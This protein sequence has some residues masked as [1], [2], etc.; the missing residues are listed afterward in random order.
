MKRAALILVV[1]LGAVLILSRTL[2]LQTKLTPSPSGSPMIPLSIAAMREKAY[3]GSAFTVVTTL[4]DT[5]EYHQ[6]VVSYVSDGLKIQGLLTE[7]KGDK[8]AGGWPAILFDHGYVDPRVYTPTSRYVEFV[9]DLTRAGYVVFK[10]DY[11]GNGKSE[12]VPDS[13]YFSP[14]YTIDN[15]NALAALKQ[16][17]RVDPARI[18]IWGH[19]M[20]GNVALRTLTSHPTDIRA[21]V[22]WAGVV[23]DYNQIINH[24]QNQPDITYQPSAYEMAERYLGKDQ[25]VAAYGE[26]AADPGFWNTIDPTKHLG[27][28]RVPVELHV[29]EHDNEV[30]EGWSVGLY[31]QLVAAGKTANLYAYPGTDHNILPPN[32]ETAMARTIAFFD[33][34]LKATH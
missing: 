21:A 26:P 16:D 12:G 11:R 33:K 32:Y 30:P 3:P 27:E 2:Y 14:N 13:P 7:P 28:I 20:G 25:L 15:L 4:P 6:W 31:Q 24:W 1:V 29:S 23:G 17:Q 22:I 19:S 34:Y 5:V 8:P 10:P 9:A 18:G